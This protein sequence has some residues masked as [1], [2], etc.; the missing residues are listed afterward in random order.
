MTHQIVFD[1]VKKLKRLYKE[2]ITTEEISVKTSFERYVNSYI[3][4]M[5]YGGENDP[6]DVFAEMAGE[7]SQEDMMVEI[8]GRVLTGDC[9]IIQLALD[10]GWE[11][12][13]KAEKLNWWGRKIVKEHKHQKQGEQ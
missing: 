4:G 6:L 1:I 7:K 12:E 13:E 9:A 10:I 8:F 3:E 11:C 2:G 5:M